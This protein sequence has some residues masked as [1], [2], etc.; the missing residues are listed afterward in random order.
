MWARTYSRPPAARCPL[1]SKNAADANS[2]H[3]RQ[4]SF[5]HTICTTAADSR[6]IFDPLA[7]PNISLRH[8][9]LLPSA[10]WL[11]LFSVSSSSRRQQKCDVIHRTPPH[12]PYCPH[13]STLIGRCLSTAADTSSQPGS[14]SREQHTV[15]AT[16]N[17]LAKI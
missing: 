17:N 15:F 14:R 10:V 16:F 4:F 3:H 9:P 7:A 1:L 6:Y 12:I 13:C 11:T 2:R 8:P 5:E